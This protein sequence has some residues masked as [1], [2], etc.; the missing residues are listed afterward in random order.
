VFCSLWAPHSLP[1]CRVGISPGETSAELSAT[2][3]GQP[4]LFCVRNLPP[5]SRIEFRVSHP[6]RAPALFEL[7]VVVPGHASSV[8]S[9][10]RA[11]LDT[12]QLHVLTDNHGVPMVFGRGVRHA[13]AS[14]A[15]SFEGC[16]ALV[17]VTARPRSP[18]VDE[19]ASAP[20]R[21]SVDPFVFGGPSSA[22]GMLR[23]LLP[24]LFVAMLFVVPW[25]LRGD[26]SPW[27]DS[28]V[29]AAAQRSCIHPD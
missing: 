20:F 2:L 24:V 25:V 17:R 3:D 14:E 6:A 19:E 11:P 23:V 9:S 15:R 10:G 1:S 18:A 16:S 7:Q 8:T 26:S 29:S 22:W 28:V 27:A 4:S 21:L 12:E 5:D 13:V